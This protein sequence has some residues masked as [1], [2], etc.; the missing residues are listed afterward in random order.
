[1]HATTPRPRGIS[2]VI[3][4]VLLVALTLVLAALV[5]S[6]LV[7]TSNPSDAARAG[8][9]ITETPAGTTLTLVDDGNVVEVQVVNGTGALI[10]ELTAVGDR[11][12]I[13]PDTG[14]VVIGVTADGVKTVLQ[15]IPTT[16]HPGKQDP[17]GDGLTNEE[18]TTLG[19]DPT[20]PDTDGDGLDDGAEVDR[21][22]DPRNPTTEPAPPTTP[23]A[24][25]VWALLDGFEHGATDMWTGDLTPSAA[26]LAGN[27]S[28]ALVGAGQATHV[29][30][31]RATG[32]SLFIS[33]QPTAESTASAAITTHTNGDDVSGARLEQ[34]PGAR[35]SL[36]LGDGTTAGTTATITE[37]TVYELVVREQDGAHTLALYTRDGRELART[38]RPVTAVD[39][40]ELRLVTPGPNA[41]LVVDDIRIRA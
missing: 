7:T 41:A 9:D 24:D 3:G 5:G 30:P 21:G 19:T 10:T 34:A 8:V 29:L 32:V 4:V 1:M 33:Y 6:A 37:G 20:D 16:E 35:A 36:T 38:T 39:L 26:A 15:T 28:G 22:T 40:T 14:A 23:A 17:D 27:H 25:G 31:G 2:P 11:V 13:P 12:S 18:E